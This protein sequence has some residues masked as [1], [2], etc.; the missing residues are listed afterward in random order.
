M[1]DIKLELRNKQID[2]IFGYHLDPTPHIHKEIELIYV[3]KGHAFCHADNK[4]YEVQEGDI[5]IC[6]P[7][8]IHYYT[9]SAL[10]EYNIIIFSHQLLHNMQNIFSENLPQ[11]HIFHNREYASLIGNLVSYQGEYK[12]TF[13][14]GL[15]N[16]LTS[17]LMS[18]TTLYP[19]I[20]TVSSTLQDIVFYCSKNFTN[21]ISLED[22]AN[23]LHINKYHISFLLNKK[24]GI[25]FSQYINSLRVGKACELMSECEKSLAF[26]SEE[27]G[28][29]SIRSFNR[30]FKEIMNI[31]PLQYYKQINSKK[32]K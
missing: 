29:G 13:C 11:K 25:K 19:K 26:I 20:N 3:K 21:D 4:P 18:E 30:A 2:I 12:E 14:A 17:Q 16:V 32:R 24:L 28:F 31:T 27:A 5:F 7:N 1:K 10:G 22:V 23:D 6:F 15:L 8:Q 9:D